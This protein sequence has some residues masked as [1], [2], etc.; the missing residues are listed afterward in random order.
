M[1][2][3]DS[4]EKLNK[5][6]LWF[7]ISKN[8]SAALSQYVYDLA[9]ESGIPVA[10]FS[11]TPKIEIQ[12]R[13]IEKIKRKYVE[14]ASDNNE[15]D[16]LEQE[17]KEYNNHGF[18]WHPEELNEYVPNGFFWSNY[19]QFDEYKILSFSNFFPNLYLIDNLSELWFE[20]GDDLPKLL[21]LIEKDAVNF[22]K[23]VIVF[24]SPTDFKLNQ[25]FIKER[26][27]I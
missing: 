11:S 19:V 13:V 17:M 21:P 24:V 18:F 14:T 22:K 23:T 8:A 7:V 26:I 6:G 16:W 5:P 3:K 1:D 15:R 9:V 2:N 20:S 25:E 12:N 4:Y 10:V 27:I